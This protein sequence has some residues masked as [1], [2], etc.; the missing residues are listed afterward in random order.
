MQN[1]Q[2]IRMLNDITITRL[3]LQLAK[4]RIKNNLDP[5]SNDNNRN[6]ELKQIYKSEKG[7]CELKPENFD[8]SKQIIKGNY[9]QI[10]RNMILILP[11][12]MI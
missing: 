4:A 1:L 3:I 2:V 11:L 10:L 12:I 5:E 9:L 8:K 7:F 6:N